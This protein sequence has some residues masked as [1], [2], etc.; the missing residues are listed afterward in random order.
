MV[1]LAGLF[2]PPSSLLHS[3]LSLPI[4]GPWWPTVTSG[5]P[6][7]TC[8]LTAVA[9]PTNQQPSTGPSLVVPPQQLEMPLPDVPNNPGWPLIWG[10]VRDLSLN[11]QFVLVSF[12]FPSSS[13][14]CIRSILLK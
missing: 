7:D 5:P 1:A 14:S 2:Y 12:D 8:K 6:M 10:Q 9:A 4:S 13:Y 11:L 3:R